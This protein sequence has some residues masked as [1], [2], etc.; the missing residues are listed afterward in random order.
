MA[1][2]AAGSPSAVDFEVLRALNVR[3]EAS[4]RAP[5]PQGCCQNPDTCVV[6]RW[7][8][9]GDAHDEVRR[10]S[11]RTLCHGLPTC[12]NAKCQ[13]FGNGGAAGLGTYCAAA[14]WLTQALTVVTPSSSESATPAD[15]AA[16]A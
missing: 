8:A 10:S 3:V 12:E 11:H 5:L 7:V 16:R 1:A 13:G 9:A 4:G 2:E 14:I 15:V 6:R